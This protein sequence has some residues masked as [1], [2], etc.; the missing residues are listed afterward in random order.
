MPE[1]F[2]KGF[3]ARALG[4]VVAGPDFAEHA[5]GRFCVVLW[6]GGGDGRWKVEVRLGTWEDGVPVDIS[7]KGWRPGKL[8]WESQRSRSGGEKVGMEMY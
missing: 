4:S 8:A 2:R 3:R 6:E 5:K 7:A 1:Q